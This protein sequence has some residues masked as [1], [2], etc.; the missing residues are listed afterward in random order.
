MIWSLIAI[1]IFSLLNCVTITLVLYLF[2]KHLLKKTAK[3]KDSLWVGILFGIVSF[4][5]GS[6]LIFGM[7]KLKQ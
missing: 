6:L 4:L 5:I 3:P 7:E 2:K 1:T